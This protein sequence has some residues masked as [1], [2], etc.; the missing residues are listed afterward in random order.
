MLLKVYMSGDLGG[1]EVD[2]FA[3][4]SLFS[5]FQR[6]ILKEIEKRWPKL[7]SRKWEFSYR[8]TYL[9]A[10]VHRFLNTLLIQLFYYFVKDADGDYMLLQTNN[11]IDAMEK[12]FKGDKYYKVYV[13]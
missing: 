5:V 8:G 2:I 3:C 4:G 12:C 6:E 10:I 7:A 13:K 11:D 1:F 9:D